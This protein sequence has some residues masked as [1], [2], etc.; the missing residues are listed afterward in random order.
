ME[1]HVVRHASDEQLQHLAA[2][3]SHHTAPG[4]Q[5][6]VVPVTSVPREA[7][8]IRRAL[9]LYG[10]ERQVLLQDGAV[11]AMKVFTQGTTKEK[12]EAQHKDGQE[13]L[14]AGPGGQ[15]KACHMATS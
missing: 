2:V 12:V 7:Q 10:L 5:D 8:L 9:D 14:H 11:V 6:A 1:R 3:S 4:R 15:R 13:S